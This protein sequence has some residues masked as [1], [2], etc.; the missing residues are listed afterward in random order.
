MFKT[1][2]VKSFEVFD[3]LETCLSHQIYA[4][5]RTASCILSWMFVAHGNFLIRA[6]PC[7]HRHNEWV[8]LQHVVV[9]DMFRVC[10][11]VRTAWGFIG[12]SLNNC[13][14]RK[15]LANACSSFCQDGTRTDRFIHQGHKFST[16]NFPCRTQLC[17]I[18]DNPTYQRKRRNIMPSRTISFQKLV[19]PW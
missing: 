18:P 7:N 10:F 11:G 3:L 4:V 2:D 15:S 19:V 13:Y 14:R 1:C 9:G 5:P 17:H 6:F 8:V 12:S 16:D